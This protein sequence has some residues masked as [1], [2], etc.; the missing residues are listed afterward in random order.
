MSRLKRFLTSSEQRTYCGDQQN[1]LARL[2]ELRRR[3]SSVVEDPESLLSR[4]SEHAK[5]EQKE[6]ELD[7]SGEAPV[8]AAYEEK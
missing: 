2:E 6:P 3:Q 8:A 4:L 1:P 5:L 7:L